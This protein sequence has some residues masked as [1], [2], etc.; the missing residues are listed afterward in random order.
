METFAVAELVDVQLNDLGPV[1]QMYQFIGDM[2]G[3][4]VPGLEPIL[5]HINE[6]L[7]NKTDPAV[8]VHSYYIT[9]NI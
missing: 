3:E 6:N 9:K 5:N 2:N 1:I 7:L 4:R 8:N